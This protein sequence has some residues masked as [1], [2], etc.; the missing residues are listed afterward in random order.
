M[1][2]SAEQRGMGAADRHRQGKVS[3]NLTAQHA[4]RCDA[5]RCDAMRCDNSMIFMIFQFHG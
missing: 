3:E 4:M 2:R 1:L 5:M